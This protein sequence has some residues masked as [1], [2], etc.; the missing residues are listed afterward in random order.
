M[1]VSTLQVLTLRFPPCITVTYPK[2]QSLSDL[3]TLVRTTLEAFEWSGWLLLLRDV[4]CPA[5][6]CNFTPRCWLPA[7]LALHPRHFVRDMRA[8]RGGLVLITSSVWLWPPEDCYF[9]PRASAGETEILFDLHVPRPKPFTRDA[10][11]MATAGGEGEDP[12]L[13]LW[14]SSVES[15]WRICGGLYVVLLPAAMC[16][17]LFR[18]T[19]S[20]FVSRLLAMNFGAA[21]VALGPLYLT[22]TL[23]SGVYP[24][25]MKL[26]NRLAACANVNVPEELF[27][28]ISGV[29]LS[30]ARACMQDLIRYCIWH[31]RRCRPQLSS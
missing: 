4:T 31:H 30:D 14:R 3:F 11:R 5:L 18:W 29:S 1:S 10:N 26:L 27:A 15:I 16:C 8:R 13:T 7:S 9:M 2:V 6:I 19:P 20:T 23:L 17:R 24:V 25:L 21:D 22:L 28:D 12:D